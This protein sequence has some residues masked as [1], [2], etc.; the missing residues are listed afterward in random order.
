MEIKSFRIKN[1]RSIKDG[2]VCYVSGD[3]ITIL[4]GK[5][6]SGKTAILEALED[7][8]TEKEIWKEAIPIHHRETVPE[9]AVTFQINKETLNEISEE[10]NL[11][12]EMPKSGNIEIIKKYPLEYSLSEETR[13]ML[14]IKDEQLF[15]KQQ[16]EITEIY[17]QIKKIHSEF[18]QLGGTLP[19]INLDNMQEFKTQLANFKNEVQPN[20]PQ[21]PDEKTRNSFSQA[22]EEIIGKIAEIN[23]SEVVEKK[24]IEQIKQWIPNFILFSSFDDIFPSE[25]PLSEASKNELIKDL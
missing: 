17:R 8:N 9:I 13:E 21:I 5:N 1:Y 20:L 22:L 15:K 14:G 2:G 6:E 10:L 23:N 12:L 7:F 24:F 11:K 16:K 4:A 18:S 25:S 3:N 19:E